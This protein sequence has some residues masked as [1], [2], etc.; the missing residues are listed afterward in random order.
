MS[1]SDFQKVTE[2]LARPTT[3][4]QPPIPS[5]EHVTILGGG[6]EAQALAGLCLAQGASTTL[7][8]AYG[9]ELEPLRKAGAITLRGEG[10]SGTYQIS[11]AASPAIQL[12]AE[13]DKAVAQADV[14]FVTGPVLKQRTYSMVLAGH[15]QEGQILVLVPGRSMGALE[16]AWYL[17]VGG[18]T[19]QVSIVE[20][21][22]VPFWVQTEGTLLH[23]TQPPA[24]SA[25]VLPRGASGI[26]QA[27]QRFFPNLTPI[28]SVVSSSFGDA[29][30]LVETVALMMGGPSFPEGGEPL[31]VGAEPLPER[32]VFRKLIGAQHRTLIE[33]LATER[34]AV[35]ARWGVRE[36]PATETWIDHHAG[37]SHGKGIRPIPHEKQAI[38]LIRCAVIGSLVPLL[39]AARLAGLYTPVTQAMVEM[40]QASLGGDLINA[41][42][43][44]DSL[45]IVAEHLD[46]ARKILEIR[47]KGGE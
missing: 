43:K 27:L 7:F 2:A 15:L 41:G 22:N 11:P 33:S 37:T 25:A 29:S 12:T 36:L 26:L 38:A 5:L 44:L 14:I 1:V 47:A 23:L 46:E 17:R 32:H 34:K 39:S 21:Q 3:S 31:P 28:E 30:G 19:A 18:E 10:P 42:R 20:L 6:L 13:L 35:A 24:L 9:I 40:A 45:G 16:M 8:S 4:L